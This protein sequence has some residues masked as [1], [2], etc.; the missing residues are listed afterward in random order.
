MVYLMRA[1]RDIHL[2]L[3][4]LGFSWT[5]VQFPLKIAAVGFGQPYE[6]TT[7]A[8]NLATTGEFRDPFGTPT[9]P[10][11]HVAPVYTAI[12][13]AAIK[14]FQEPAN[15]A[16]AMII[17]NAVLFGWAASLLPALS[18]CVYGQSAP[19][20]AGG[21]LLAAA[22]WMMPQWE[23][24]LSA[25]LFMT[26]TLALVRSGPVRAGLWSGI[27]L[28][29]NPVC[30]LALTVVGLCR[31]WGSSLASG[32]LRGRRFALPVAGLALA[33]CAPWILRNW[34]ELGSPFF[35]RDN[36]GLEVYIS[37][38]DRA[39]AEFVTNWPLWHLHPNQN[40][41]E[42]KLV[43]AMGEGLYN[44]MRFRSASEW[45]RTHPK[46]FLKLSGARMWYYWFPSSQEGWPAYLYWIIGVLSLWGLWTSRTNGWAVLLALSAVVYSLTFTVISTHLRYHFPSLWISALIA[47]CG[48]I[49]IFK[50]VRVF[51]ARRA[52]GPGVT[53][54]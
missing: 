39:S 38:Q 31:S 22:G 35:V 25:L 6:L 8:S 45:I 28:L 20:L 47:G 18:R 32:A 15:V 3:F 46:E 23:T 12:L 27:C 11:A 7:V 36:L 40:P 43:A 21:V 16:L 19:G 4:L 44:Q 52:R 41:E 14:L 17:L 54:S 5:L 30:L 29:A 34:V 1:L 10:T 51:S 42:A 50:R 2:P 48:A 53:I 9:G 24:A 26:A 33:I 37:N 13:A 49:E